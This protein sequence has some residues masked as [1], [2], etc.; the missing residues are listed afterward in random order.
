[1]AGRGSAWSDPEVLKLTREFVPATD[2]SWRLQTSDDPQ[3]EFFRTML[4]GKPDRVNGSR[5]GTYVCTPGGRLLA[6]G[7][8]RNPRVIEKILREGLA[9]WQALSEEERARPVPPGIQPEHRFEDFFPADGLALTATHR[10]W[11]PDDPGA[12]GG[13]WNLDHLWI[14][15]DEVSTWMRALDGSPDPVPL[16]K[17]LVDRWVRLHLVDNVR[18]QEGP[19]APEDIERATMTARVEMTRGRRAH[20]V[21][22]GETR[23]VSDGVWKLGDNL[24]KNFKNRPRGVETEILGQAIYDMDRGR[25]V[26]F[27]LVA[28]GRSW[29]GSGLNGRSSGGPESSTPLAWRFELSG[30]RPADRVPPAF[31]DIYGASWVR[32]PGS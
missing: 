21:I 12:S 2:E 22:E 28:V 16:P 6:R 1:M 9:A 8:S 26:A 27:S 4:H 15:H 3:A 11:N 32:L 25:F 23:A 7:N 14:S 24:W 20:L 13:R 5:Q 30:D 18:G 31:I 10:D 17:A 19:F 29:G